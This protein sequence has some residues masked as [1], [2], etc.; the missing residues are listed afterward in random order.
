MSDTPV[1][2]PSSFF[3]ALRLFSNSDA[4]K[5]DNLNS[6]V[7]KVRSLYG[8]LATFKR[9]REKFRGYLWLVALPHEKLVYNKLFGMNDGL[10][11]DE[12]KQIRNEIYNSLEWKSAR[13]AV[14]R[15]YTS[16]C[17]AAFPKSDVVIDDGF[18]TEDSAALKLVS[19]GDE[20][21]HVVQAHVPIV[22]YI[23]TTTATTI[24]TQS[25]HCN[26]LQSVFCVIEYLSPQLSAY[27][28][29]DLKDVDE[30]PLSFMQRKHYII[31]QHLEIHLQ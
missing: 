26:S 13:Q 29:S 2:P 8:T 22:T 12:L 30:S 1:A 9:Y 7:L 3:E 4:A 24:A 25:H 14:W 23:A 11:L 17:N 6:L 27:T 21:Y 18:A 20:N 10:S 5:T 19:A 15:R 31:M 16:I 28:F